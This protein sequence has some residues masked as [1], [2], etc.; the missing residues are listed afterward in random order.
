MEANGKK[1]QKVSNILAIFRQETNN[2]F[3]DKHLFFCLCPPSLKN[4]LNNVAGI[5]DVKDWRYK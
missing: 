5:D 1:Q 4:Y 2:F 3:Q